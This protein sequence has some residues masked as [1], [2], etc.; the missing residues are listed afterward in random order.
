MLLSLQQSI[1]MRFI[2][3]M[4]FF[5]MHCKHTIKSY[6]AN[7]IYTKLK[8]LLYIANISEIEHFRFTYF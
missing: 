3:Y 7:S 6:Q 1:K 4:Q 5:I 8:V 2:C